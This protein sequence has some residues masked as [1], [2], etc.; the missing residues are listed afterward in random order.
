[1]SSNQGD[2]LRPMLEDAELDLQIRVDEVCEEPRISKETTGELIRLEESLSLAAE[3][4][5]KAVSL[6]RRL[7]QRDSGASDISPRPD[8][9]APGG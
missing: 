7:R 5:K 2:P 9:S 1:M 4:A 6:R 3:A 8:L